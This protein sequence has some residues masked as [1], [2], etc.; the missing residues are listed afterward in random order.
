MIKERWDKT[1]QVHQ[2]LKVTIYVTSITW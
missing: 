2:K 1:Q